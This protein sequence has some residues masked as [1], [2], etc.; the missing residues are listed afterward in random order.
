MHDLLGVVAS[1]RAIQH[2]A[3]RDPTPWI[4]PSTLDF[5][6]ARDPASCLSGPYAMDT[7][8]H[9]RPLPCVRSSSMPLGYL[10]LYQRHHAFCHC[11]DDVTALACLSGVCILT[12][13]TIYRVATLKARSSSG[14]HVRAAC[15]VQCC[16]TSIS[17]VQCS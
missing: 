3:S 17:T 14:D 7:S 1:M 6:H 13:V 10:H 5:C 12:S 11:T 16:R 2:H 4:L 8:F 9:P 15:A